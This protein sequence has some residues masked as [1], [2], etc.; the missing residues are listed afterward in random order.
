L[1]ERCNDRA[2]IGEVLRPALRGLTT[3]LETLREG[4]DK[5]CARSVL[6]AVVDHPGA[7]ATACAILD[8]S[9]AWEPA[10]LT[11]FVEAVTHLY[12][13]SPA[14]DAM[15][16]E[17]IPTFQSRAGRDF[18]K[19][20]R[21]QRLLKR[22]GLGG[23]DALLLPGAVPRTPKM[24]GAPMRGSSTC[25]ICSRSRSYWQSARTT[26]VTSSSSIRGCARPTGDSPCSASYTTRG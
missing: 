15:R 13:T 26:A 22:L 25:A 12:G 16:R 11:A 7:A 6:G 5:Y 19:R 18:T 20:P 17:V 3:S 24:R 8:E 21:I 9:A 14:R 23:K 1:D 2:L 4:G 10:R